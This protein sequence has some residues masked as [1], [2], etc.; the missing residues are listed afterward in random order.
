MH[1]KYHMIITIS[2]YIYMFTHSCQPRNLPV[3]LY[4]DPWPPA[5]AAAARSTT[6][7]PRWPCRASECSP[8]V[9]A[10]VGPWR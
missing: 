10:S 5:R 4:P 3:A 6:H 7:H 9:A 1:M 2:Y 8:D